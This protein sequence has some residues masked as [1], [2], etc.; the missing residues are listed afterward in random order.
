MGRKSCP[1]LLF[2]SLLS[3]TLACE[4]T[5]ASSTAVPRCP[6]RISSLP[7]PPPLAES[8]SRTAMRT[9]TNRPPSTTHSSSK[10]SR[11]WWRRC[12]A[13]IAGATASL[14]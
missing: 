8:S 13:P 6:G 14:A 7:Q 9:V 1:C 3:I 2:C 4:L 10:G 11:S 12:R 5:G